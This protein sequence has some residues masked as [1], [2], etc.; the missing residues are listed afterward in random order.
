MILQHLSWS[1]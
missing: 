1:V